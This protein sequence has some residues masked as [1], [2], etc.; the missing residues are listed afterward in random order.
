VIEMRER[1][2]EKTLHDLAALKAKYESKLAAIEAIVKD[3]V[4]S[5]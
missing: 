2:I 5:S 3:P 1:E 4:S